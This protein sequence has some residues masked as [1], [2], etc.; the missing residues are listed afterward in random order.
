MSKIAFIDNKKVLDS[1]PQY[2]KSKKRINVEETRLRSA[3][4]Q[5]IDKQQNQ[6]DFSVLDFLHQASEMEEKIKFRI[7]KLNQQ[8]MLRI[9]TLIEK[10]ITIIAERDGYDM[11]VEKGIVQFTK[12]GLDIS[13]EVIAI[14]RREDGADVDLVKPEKEESSNNVILSNELVLS[15]SHSGLENTYKYELG[16]FLNISDHIVL[17]PQHRYVVPRDG[18]WCINYTFEGDLFIGFTKNKLR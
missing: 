7:E 4:D 13:E 15:M 5:A 11:V 18:I 8:E 9:N 17:F 2:E 10:A 6:E 12:P 1:I 14:L 3:Y 16:T